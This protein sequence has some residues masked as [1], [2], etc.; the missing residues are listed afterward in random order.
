[1]TF[2]LVARCEKTGMLGA[3]VASSSPAVAAR[4]SFAEAGI[5]AF[6]SQNITDP[7]LG[8]RGLALIRGGASAPE[9]L[10][11][12]RRESS[13]I[14]YRQ[15][16]AVDANGGAAVFS[17]KHTLGVHAEARTENVAAAGNLLANESV[18]GAMTSSFLERAGEHLGDR[19]VAALEAAL[20]AG[21]E[22]GPVHSAG[23]KIVREAPWPYADLRCDWSDEC[24]VAA[25]KQ[26]WIIYKP[27]MDDYVRRALDP[28]SAPAYNVPGEKRG[29][30]P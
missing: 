7:R 11:A 13:E 21:G 3:A 24:P 10:D 8:V 20:T 18:I 29:D 16:L 2:A 14:E 22:A 6:S 25:L 12:I 5:G 9:A 4:C 1:M 30:S 17:G 28:A 26:A 15:L 23:M 27:Q 19:L